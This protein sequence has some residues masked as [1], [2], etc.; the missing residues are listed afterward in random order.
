SQLAEMRVRDHDVTSPWVQCLLHGPGDL[1]RQAFLYLQ[2][3]AE[4]LHKPGDLAESH[5][6]VVGDI[7]DVALPVEGQ[8]VVFAETE[9]VDVADHHHLVVLDRVESTVK[10]LFNILL[11]PLCEDP[12]RLGNPLGSLQEPFARRV[13]TE[14]AE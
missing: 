7:G 12:E 10:D 5:H 14:K 11:I 8:E 13:L 2:A 4:H 3:P 6:T 1:H 9:E